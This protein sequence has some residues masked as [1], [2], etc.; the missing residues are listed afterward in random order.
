M[1]INFGGAKSTSA[2][3]AATST[4]AIDENKRRRKIIFVNDS[5][6]IIYLSKG[7]IAIVNTGIRLNA[8]GGSYEDMPDTFGRIYKGAY[9]AIATGAGSV[10]NI[11]EEYYD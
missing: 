7:A 11:T 5:A 9:N 8:N 2:T 6:N 4:L 1:G 10:L 3:I